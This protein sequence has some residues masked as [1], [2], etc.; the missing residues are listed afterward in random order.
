MK[1][2]VDNNE[3]PIGKSA[4]NPGVPGTIASKSIELSNEALKN[5]VQKAVTDLTAVLSEV[6]A[7][8]GRCKISEIKF[9]LSITAGGEA[10]LLSVVKGSLSGTTGIEFTLS[11]V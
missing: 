9:S 5:T 8:Q 11:F 1:I 7:D 10:A 4:F 2:L 6:K 3:F